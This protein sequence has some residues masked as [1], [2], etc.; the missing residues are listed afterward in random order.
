MQ[1]WKKYEEKF[2]EHVTNTDDSV[3]VFYHTAVLH[4]RECIING[5]VRICV[6]GFLSS[7]HQL[8]CAVRSISNAY[9][10][11][12]LA[13]QIKAEIEFISMLRWCSCKDAA[14]TRPRLRVTC[15]M[16]AIFPSMHHTHTQIEASQ[17]A[18]AFAADAA[19]H[20]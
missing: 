8:F 5:C 16:D 6:C 11:G 2:V 1:K 15:V 13:M 14:T 17:Q 3:C 9:V 18:G 19:A 7:G 12:V 20:I 10:G 4:I